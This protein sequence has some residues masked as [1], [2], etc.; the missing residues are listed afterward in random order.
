MEIQE[1]RN[2][3]VETAT[4]PSFRSNQCV[5]DRQTWEGTATE[6]VNQLPD[7]QLQANVLSRRLNTVNSQLLND[8]GI[9]YD[10]KRGHERKI[11][12]KRLEAK[13]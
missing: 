2:R 12:L 4:E 13:E 8:Y 5:S 1:S 10:N 9:F 3:V 6:L 11:I 7:M